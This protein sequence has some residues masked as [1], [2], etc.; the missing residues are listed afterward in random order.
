MLKVGTLAIMSSE[1]TDESLFD[2]ADLLLMT[3]K[4]VDFPAPDGPMTALHW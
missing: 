2:E 3:S 4:K 1:Y